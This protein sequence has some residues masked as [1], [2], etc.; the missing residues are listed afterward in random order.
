[1]VKNDNWDQKIVSAGSQNVYTRRQPSW[2]NELLSYHKQNI[3]IVKYQI[4]WEET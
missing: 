3:N 1:M 2:N 4:R